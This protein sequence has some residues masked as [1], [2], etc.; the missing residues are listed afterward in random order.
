MNPPPTRLTPAPG[1][2]T[3][4]PRAA[5]PIALAAIATIHAM[6]AA[7]RQAWVCDDAFISFR[8]AANLNRGVGLVF[9]AG[10]RVEGYSNF[11]WTLWLALGMRLGVAPE[12]WSVVSGV[13]C[14]GATIALLG[15][16]AL[17]RAGPARGWI[18]AVPIAAMLAAAHSDW[19]A[20]ATSGLETSLFTL[21]A[22]IGFVLLIEADARPRALAI[23]GGTLALAALTRPDGAIF[24]ALGGA[25]VI[26]KRRPR[27]RSALA[28]SWPA[29]AILVPFAAWRLWYYGD[30]APNTYYA[31]S[32]YLA[33]YSQGWIYLRLYFERYWILALGPPLAALAAF[34]GRGREDAAPKP[35]WGEEA[36]LAALFALGY[37]FWVLR[38]GGDFMHARLL[39]P[40]TPFLLILL[41]LAIARLASSRPMLHAA[42]AAAAVAALVLAPDP[43]PAGKWVSGI[44]SERQFYTPEATRQTREEGMRLQRYF[45]GLPV[46]VAFVGSQ[47][48]LVY[49]ADPAVA[50][51]SQTGLTDRFV[52]HQPLR[53]RGR[54]GHEKLAP[55]D[56]LIE[57]RHVQ[58]VLH[59]FAAVTLRL[60]DVLPHVVMALDSTY[61]Q[62]VTWDPKLVADLERR[63]ARCPDFPA[64]LDFYIARMAALPDEQV[65]ADYARVR[66]FY[67]AQVSDRAREHSFRARLRLPD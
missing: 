7:A 36:S 8:Y 35:A 37:A 51:E 12:R 23:A 64:V 29:I 60:D 56:Y 63:G 24:L 49:Y 13:A 27:L 47:A 45:A 67:F 48:G 3:R 53:A 40:A 9:N 44:V 19:N 15:W 34:A 31:K 4:A 38:V 57:R 61:A 25:H 33:W 18:A 28:Y 11:L 39:I 66:R 58:L 1:P 6:A 42:A 14:Y 50:I 52:A 55:L 21:L 46:R 65:A 54:V 5:L 17:R 2:G 30:L 62:L 16:R 22:T 10:E 41:E 59:H 43:L 26:A 20:Y 32:A